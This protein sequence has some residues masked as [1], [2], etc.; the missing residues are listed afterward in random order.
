MRGK[1]TPKFS[2]CPSF[3]IV[4]LQFLGSFLRIP[5]T[6]SGLSIQFVVKQFFVLIFLFFIHFFFVLFPWNYDCLKRIYDFS[7]DIISAKSEQNQLILKMQV[8]R[9]KSLV[10]FQFVYFRFEKQCILNILYK[11]IAFLTIALENVLQENFQ[12]NHFPEILYFSSV[13]RI[14]NKTSGTKNK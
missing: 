12:N 13:S 3:I 7:K 9:E 14:Y 4:F 10:N 2:N 6:Q 1:L 11:I 8:F 5:N